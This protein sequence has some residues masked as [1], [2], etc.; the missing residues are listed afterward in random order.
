MPKRMK[1][2]SMSETSEDADLEDTMSQQESEPDG[3]TL[4]SEDTDDDFVTLAEIREA[5]ILRDAKKKL[6]AQPRDSKQAVK[7]T[8]TQQL[9]EKTHIDAVKAFDELRDHH[10]AL[11]DAKKITYCVWGLEAA[12]TTGKWHGQGYVELPA[13]GKKTKVGVRKLYEMLDMPYP[14]V[15]IANGT[16][17]QNKEYCLKTKTEKANVHWFEFG[18][19]RSDARGGP[20]SRMKMDWQKA[21]DQAVQGDFDSI[22]PC[23]L[24]QHYTNLEKVGFAAKRAYTDLD[25]LDNVWVHGAPGVG[26]SMWARSQARPGE[27]LYFK[28]AMNKWFDGYQHEELVVIDDFEKD[29]KYQ[30]HLLK[31]LGDRYPL[32][33]EIKGAS[34]WVRPKRVIITSNYKIEDIWDDPA[35][36][37]ALKRRFRVKYIE[38]QCVLCGERCVQG[39]CPS[40]SCA[41]GEVAMV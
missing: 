6:A 17:E 1:M 11:F 8:L 39:V 25:V 28:D 40:A 13:G 14:Y 27:R 12:P 23:I 4:G 24:I 20:G 26:K 21:K 34:A 41:K 38:P 3:E 31:T 5:N 9:E 2:Q 7:F 37:A 18:A 29:S 30:A 36:V 15:D 19:A 32:R 22:D 16:A 35:I 33:V 10:K